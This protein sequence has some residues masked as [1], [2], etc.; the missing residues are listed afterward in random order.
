MVKRRDFLK[1]IP[2]AVLFPLGLSEVVGKENISNNWQDLTLEKTKRLLKEHNTDFLFLTIKQS[3]NNTEY[4]EVSY[5]PIHRKARTGIPIFNGKPIGLVQEADVLN[6]YID[7]LTGFK[8][9][10]P[11]YTRLYGKV[12]LW[13]PDSRQDCNNQTTFTKNG[14][15]YS[16]TWGTIV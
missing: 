7:V 14:R 8:N 3:Y 16:Y 2:A 5:P 12:Q 13:I 6:G 11:Q 9:G 15:E 10:V 4:T 1:T